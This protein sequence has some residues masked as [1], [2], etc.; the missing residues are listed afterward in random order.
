[1]RVCLKGIVELFL[2]FRGAKLESG[3]AWEALFIIVLIVR[4]MTGSFLDAVVPLSGS[5]VTKTEVWYNAPFS[6]QFDFGT[7]DPLEFLQ[8]VFRYGD[9]RAVHAR[10]CR[11]KHDAVPTV[12]LV[13]AA[14]RLLQAASNLQSKLGRICYTKDAVVP[15]WRLVPRTERPGRHHSWLRMA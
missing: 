12:P 10:H 3:E 15:I 11:R 5:L 7:K 13:G 1:M 14:T 8:G 4:C 6:L 9:G 2:Q